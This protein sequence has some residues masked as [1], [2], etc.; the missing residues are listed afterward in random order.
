MQINWAIEF[1]LAFLIA[2]LYATFVEYTMHRLM[3][4]GIV[5]GDQHAKHHQEDTG[6]GWFEEFGNYFIP[7]LTILWFGFLCSTVAGIGF[8]LGGTLASVWGAYAHQLQHENPEL[9]FWLSRPVHHLHHKHNMAK[10]NFGISV[11]FWDRIFGTYRAGKWQ[12]EKEPSEYPLRS[13]V[14]IR[15]S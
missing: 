15:W 7:S 1:L 8:A 9:V 11:D 5:Y 12:P 4:A 14:G 6:K 10:H 13:F 3:H 2:V